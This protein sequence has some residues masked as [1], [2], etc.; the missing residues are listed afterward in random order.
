VNIPAAPFKQLVLLFAA[1][2][3]TVFSP[4]AIAASYFPRADRIHGEALLVDGHNDITSVILDSGFDLGERG[5]HPDGILFD[6]KK[7]PPPRP[8]QKFRTQTDLRRM[9]QGG[10]DA[11]F[12]S[13]Y[14]NARWLNQKPA[15]G[16]GPARRA[17][18]MIDALGRQISKHSDEMELARGVADIRRIVRRGKL[19]ALMGLEGGYAIE[20]SLAVLR[21][22]HQLG[23]RYMTLTHTDT[24]DWADSSGDIDNP[25]VLHHDGLTDFGRDVVREM[26]RL[27]M[28]VDVSHV[29]DSTFWDVLE[30]TRAPVIASHS[31]C[32]ALA[33]HPRNLTDDMLR[34]LG[35]NGGVIML[36]FANEFVDQRV[37]DFKKQFRSFE[38]ATQKKYPDDPQ[39][40]RAECQAFFSTNY[41][42]TTVSLFVNHIDHV[43]KVAGIDHVGLGSDFDGEIT[44]PVGL[45]DVS[46]FPAITASLA[47]RGYS[48][49][50]IKKVLG[51]NLL[52]VMSA[53]EAK[54]GGS[55]ARDR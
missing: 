17:L 32:R 2:I 42:R 29:A 13:I 41:P 55:P 19:A 6:F 8:G 16:G 51:E 23:I 47:Q 18:D 38:L 25:A 4:A 7:P 27:G 46:R 22:F 34:A 48:D 49:G 9:K 50:D 5:D 43:V 35:T 11:Q 10:V 30:T 33:D 28:M 39:K 21:T 54:A 26:N 40:A 15:E 12:F 24:T 36:N 44:P 45:E 20:N 53:V 37:V 52:R 31:S 14:V 1:A 3:C